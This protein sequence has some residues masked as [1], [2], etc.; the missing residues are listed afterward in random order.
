MSQFDDFENASGDSADEISVLKGHDFS[1]AADGLG[2]S[3]ALA[4][5]GSLSPISLDTRASDSG[6]RDFVVPNEQPA[7]LFHSFSQ[8]DAVLSTRIPHLGHLAL[9]SAFLLFGFCCMG[10]LLAI[11]LHFHL[12]GVNSQDQIKSNVYYLLGGETLLYLVALALSLPLFSMLWNKNFFDGIHWRGATTLKLG[13]LLPLISLGCF[14]LALLDES[15]LPCSSK[16]PIE[17]VFRTPGAAWLMFGFGV[18][19]APFFE[20]MIFRG[21]M[22]PALATACDWIN[23]RFTNK[24]PRPLDVNGHPLWSTPAMVIASILTSLPFALMHAEQQGHSIGPF[25]LLVTVSL[26][27][28]AVRLKTRSLAASTM[29]HACYNFLLFAFM[30]MGTGGFRHFDKM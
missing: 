25:L 5:V 4:P 16:A 24:L 20:E 13:W 15:L 22:L 8:P 30:M 17:V 18:T 23:E 26:V 3:G 14:G 6:S 9:L 12:G 27:L 11:S 19:L 21:F 1:R 2:D 28:C 29:V 7:E 10:V